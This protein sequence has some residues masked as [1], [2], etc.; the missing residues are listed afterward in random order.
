MVISQLVSECCR[1][2]GD[3]S[4]TPML[5]ARVIV[6][7]ALGIDDIRLVLDKYKDVD[8]KLAEAAAAMAEKR[9]NHMPIAYI[10]GHREFM[11]LD[12]KVK[13][14]VLIPRPDTECVVEAVIENVSGGNILDIGT[15][16]G[17]IAVS[18]AKYI[19]KSSVTAIDISDEA[20]E[21]A[22]SN[23]ECNGVSVEFIK[24]DIFKFRTDKIFDC[25]VSNPPYIESDEISGLMCDVKD[26]EPRTALDGGADGLVFYRKIA[27][28]CKTNLRAGGKL[29]FE[30][31]YN[32]Y[33]AV[34]TILSGAGFESIEEI[35]DLA[36]VKRG[37]GAVLRG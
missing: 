26:F 30:H 1:I 37:C 28:F 20:L 32:Q 34:K 14:G 12:F 7:S 3:S 24:A 8:G 25:I 13:S 36:G 23:A 17:A 9:R 35:Y 27:N 22:K 33:D 10:T 16:S 2:I 21:T 31:G 29:F 4:D 5:D 18:L 15:G 11:S 19:P 6:K